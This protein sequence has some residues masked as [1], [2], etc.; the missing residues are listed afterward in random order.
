MNSV[1]ES[2]VAK[3]DV[4]TVLLY[5]PFMPESSSSVGSA[6]EITPSAVATF[7]AGCFWGVEDLFLHTP[8]VIDTAVG[9]MGGTLEHPIYEMVCSGSTGHAEVVQ[10]TFAPLKVSYTTLLQIFWDN[11]NPTTRNQQGPDFGSQYRSV[12]FYHSPEQQ[13][14]AEQSKK[15][16]E[17]SGTWKRPVVTEIT[18]AT[19]FWRAEEYH[20]KYHQKNGGSCRV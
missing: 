12:I 7:G 1:H 4:G 14:M 2:M 6:A 9:Y 19:S 13:K 3:S 18:P 8:G 10:V 15:E 17:A 5:T 16:L 20:Q 11:H